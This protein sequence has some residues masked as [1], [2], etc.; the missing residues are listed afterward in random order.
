[1]LIFWCS[2]T[3]S[4]KSVV[5]P[6][7][8]LVFIPLCIEKTIRQR[9][10]ESAFAKRLPV[11]SQVCFLPPSLPYFFLWLSHLTKDH[12]EVCVHTREEQQY[13]SEP[14]IS[15]LK[16]RWIFSTSKSAHSMPVPATFISIAQGL[17]SVREERL[18]PYWGFPSWSPGNEF[19]SLKRSV[20]WPISCFPPTLSLPQELW[21]QTIL[22]FHFSQCPR[23]NTLGMSKHWSS[24]KKVKVRNPVLQG[25]IRKT[26]NNSL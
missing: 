23:E 16:C 17:K 22:V 7:K 18:G 25:I 5:H 9:F 11:V 26:G 3:N 4:G 6:M 14:Q 15:L 13:R 24:S 10:P 1:M 2:E 8:P 12:T 21:Y 19:P 20:F